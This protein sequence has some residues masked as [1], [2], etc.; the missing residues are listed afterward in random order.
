[1][2]DHT[3]TLDTVLNVLNEGIAAVGGIK[4]SLQHI[5]GI[6]QGEYDI[7]SKSM[8]MFLSN[9]APFS[10]NSQSPQEVYVH[11]LLHATTALAIRENP[12]VGARIERLYDQTEDALNSKWGEGKGYKVF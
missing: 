12:L 5:N 1:M 4:L 7:A 6:T 9:N 10:N 11:E 8:K 2:D 3:Q